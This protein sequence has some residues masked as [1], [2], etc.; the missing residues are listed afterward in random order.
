MGV[1]RPA[2][3][4]IIILKRP[5][6]NAIIIPKK[7]AINTTMIPIDNTIAAPAREPC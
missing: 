2:I 4:A 1:K 3:N 6:I 5:A 7:P